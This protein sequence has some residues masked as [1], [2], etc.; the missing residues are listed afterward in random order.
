[1]NKA[2]RVAVVTRPGS[3]PGKRNCGWWAYP[4]PEF[5]WRHFEVAKGAEL[6]RARFRGYDCIVWED[7][8]SNIRWVSDGPP[9]SYVV[10]DSTL[11]EQ[12]Y[13]RR[14]RL[15]RQ[16]DLIL[17]DWDRLERFAGLRGQV[18][19][20]SY[21]V[22]D[23][24]FRDWGL[25]K[26]VDVAYHVNEDTPER[27][28]LGDWLGR[29]CQE[30]GWAYAR[31]V[32]LGDDYARSFSRAKVTVNV[33]RTP[34]TRNHRLFDALAC[35]TCLVTDP[36][37]DVS[38]EVRQAGL[39]YLEWRDRDEL[40]ALLER[41]VPGEFGCYAE[42]GYRLVHERHTWAARAGELRVTIGEVLPWLA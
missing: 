33:N 22:N 7:G 14:L 35:R 8:K 15:G 34:T 27:R 16:A 26:D 28:T 39:H 11:S 37:P 23:R 18:R 24:R 31:G 38:G 2:L 5:T 40:V 12:H 9:I 21:C 19:R 1:M 32:R 29:L 25:P 4:V 20:L 13:Q 6:S 36:A 41:L 30:R 42:N 3:V 17:V 10:G